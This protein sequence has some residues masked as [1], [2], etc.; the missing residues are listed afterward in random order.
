MQRPSD[1]DVYRYLSNLERELRLM[2]DAALSSSS[3]TA[4]MAA[5]VAMRKLADA[6]SALF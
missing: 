6:L 4:L 1:Y 2:A 5:S 3:R